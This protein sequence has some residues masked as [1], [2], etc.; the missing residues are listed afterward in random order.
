MANKK[1]KWWYM[2]SLVVFS[3]YCIISARP[4]PKETI[5]KPQWITSM[6]LNFPV[7]LGDLS[8]AEPTAEVRQDP[9]T[10]PGEN[11]QELLPFRLNDR[12]GYVGAD[13]RFTVNQNRT[14]YISMSENMWAEYGAQPSSIRVMSARNETLMDIENIRGYPLFLDNRIFIVGSEQNSLTAIGNNGEELWTYDFPAP[15]TCIDAARGLV[16][17]GTLDGSVVLLNSRGTPAFTPFEPGGSRLSIILGCAISRD[18]SRLAIISGIDNQRFLLLEHFAD[19][20]RVIYH[21]FLSTGFR[22]PV[23]ISFVD[24]DTKVAFERE[25]GLGIYDISSRTS[26]SLSLEG[27]IVAM[28]NSGDDR[29]L[30]LITSQGPMQK[31]FI[32]I[33]YPGAVVIEAPFRSDSAFLARRGHSL[34]IGGDS[35]LASLRLE[36]K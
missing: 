6:E 10:P 26:V 8:V 24:N 16:L 23:H 32:S 36:R 5:L 2:L 18:G 1:R 33:R 20:Y 17:A 29:F 31:R 27:D 19:T 3:A 15:I 30:F 9:G 11:G 34:F 13:G 22:R 14:G 21:E 25:G 28:D 12:F 7:I 35:T 4:I